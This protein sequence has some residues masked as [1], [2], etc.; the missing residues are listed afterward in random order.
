MKILGLLFIFSIFFF[1]AVHTLHYVKVERPKL[2][3]EA[4]LLLA[5]AEIED[6]RPVSRGGMDLRLIGS[7]DAL[8][9]R[10]RAERMVDQIFGLRALSLANFIESPGGLQTTYDSDSLEVVMQ[11]SLGSKETV[12]AVKRAIQE[13]NSLPVRDRVKIHGSIK[14]PYY[15][16]NQKFLELVNKLHKTP[17]PASIEAGQRTL[18][19]KGATTQD[20]QAEW[21]AAIKEVERQTGR[22]LDIDTDFQLFPSRYHMPGY[23][24]SRRS[25]LNRDEFN[26]LMAKLKLHQIYFDSGVSTINHDDQL[27]KKTLEDLVS[28]INQQR[29]SVY[30]VIGGH[31]D[32]RGNAADNRKLAQKRAETVKEWLVFKGIDP[33]HLEVVSFGSTMAGGNQNSAEARAKARRVELLIY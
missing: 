9:E 12:D 13:G 23:F 8:E 27:T 15:L 5:E 20:M 17:H 32:S 6:V 7:V 18:R 22:R 11:G 33:N 25:K 26:R 16:T 24:R 30:F 28:L 2:L 14:E 1:T 19:L 10:D 31:A 3:E 21:L 29:S 4:D